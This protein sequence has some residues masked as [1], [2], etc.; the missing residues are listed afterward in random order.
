MMNTTSPAAKRS[1]MAI[2]A[3]MAMQIRRAED[4]L[5]MPGLWMIRQT[6]RYKSGMPLMTIVA[7]AGSNGR[8][9]SRTDV[10]PNSSIR[11]GT[12]SSS[13][14]APATI[15]MGSPARKSLSFFN[16]V[17]PPFPPDVNCNSFQT[18]QLYA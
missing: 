7:H 2:A 5:L 12:R 16:I 4:I 9:E 14:N 6:A 10:P 15:V 13:R 11:C 17:I 3:N 8:K 18:Q 1:P